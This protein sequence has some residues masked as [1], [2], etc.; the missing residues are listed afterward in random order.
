MLTARDAVPDRV[1]RLGSG[2]ADYLMKPFVIHEL[3]ARLR[4][5]G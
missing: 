3:L 2:A 5:R 1:L 4:G